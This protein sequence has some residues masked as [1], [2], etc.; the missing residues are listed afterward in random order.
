MTLGG[1]RFDKAYGQMVWQYCGGNAGLAGRKLRRKSSG[2][3]APAILRVGFE[4]GLLC[5]ICKLHTSGGRKRGEYRND[6]HRSEQRV[7]LVE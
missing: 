4:S 3:Y 1:Q 6:E 5:R 2:S 7:E